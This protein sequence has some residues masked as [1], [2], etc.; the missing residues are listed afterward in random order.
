MRFIDLFAGLGGFHEALAGLGHECVFASELNPEL[1]DVYR[2]NFP[3]VAAHVYGDIRDAKEN[4]PAHDVLCAGFPCQPFSKS[5]FQH[6]LLDET[7]GT[8]F[9]EII[10]ILTVHRP[11]F[12]L[13]ENVGN[14]ERHDEGRT[15][16][17]VRRNLEDLGYS[18]RGTVHLASGGHGLISPHH[19]GHPH[20]RERFFIVGWQGGEL[21]A[22]PFPRGDRRRTTTLTEIVQPDDQ[23]TDVDRIETALSQKQI[24]CIEHWNQLL[25]VLSPETSIPSV[26]IWGDEL[27]ATYPF[28]DRTPFEEARLALLP[29]VDESHPA[30]WEQVQAM[31]LDLPSYAR[32]ESFPVWK[33][34]FIRKNR[35][36][37]QEV[38]E[39]IPEGWAEVLKGFPP[40]L[41]KL[42]WNCKGEERDLWRYVLQ[43][44]P[45]GLRVKRYTSVPALVAMTTTQI[46][47]LG[48]KRRFI[49]RDEGKL[50]QGFPRDH[51]LPKT[52]EAAFSALG[53]AVHVDVV[54]RIAQNV[55]N[56]LD[57]L[58]AVP[59][60]I[61]DVQAE[62]AFLPG[63]Q[64]A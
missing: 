27:D 37:F 11:E 61:D 57:G 5:G 42:E 7:R 22:D 43:F 50:L 56:H 59:A 36:W 25:H 15:W 58:A 19:F 49:T 20:H 3:D 33:K 21:P 34:G 1:R 45:S 46:P 52:R 24:E 30:C 26:P 64:A 55:L 31:L 60:P 54:R 40:S 9:H 41:R 28:E 17:I 53:N 32:A 51:V 35:A 12:V 4:V 39:A 2:R 16:A 44:R 13:L 62:L 14:F 48:P 38:S 23:L 10:S 6:G 47:I 63:V 8:L 18:V 29:G